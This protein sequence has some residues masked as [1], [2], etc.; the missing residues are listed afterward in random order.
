MKRQHV[1][2]DFTLTFRDDGHLVDWRCSRD[3][4]VVNGVEVPSWVEERRHGVSGT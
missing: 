2:G 1:I 4:I 3:N